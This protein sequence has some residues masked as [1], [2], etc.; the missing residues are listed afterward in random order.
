MTKWAIAV[1]CTYV[2]NADDLCDGRN[3]LGLKVTAPLD[4]VLCGF[5]DSPVDADRRC[6]SCRT[7]HVDASLTEVSGDPLL[8][9]DAA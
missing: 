4:T 6:H 5:C 8:R 7:V 2:I 1:N 9:R 3:K